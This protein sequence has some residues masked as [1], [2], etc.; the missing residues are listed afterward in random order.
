M[1]WSSPVSEGR[2]KAPHTMDLPFA[3]DN[4]ALAP[5]MVGATPELQARA[6][7]MADA[8][9]ESYIAFTKTGNPNNKHVPKWPNFDLA[10][11]PTM[12]FDD[13]V[14]IENDPRKPQRLVIQQVPYVP[15]Q[16]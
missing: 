3:F 12:I 5:G 11:R 6:Q 13:Q 1:D 14:R 4:V 15:N 7:A 2:Y 9:S 16:T 10:H 8:V